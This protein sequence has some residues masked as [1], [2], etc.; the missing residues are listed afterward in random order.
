MNQLKI[1]LTTVGGVAFPSTI[2]AFREFK[3]GYRV[4][5]FGTDKNEN[6]VGKFFVNKFF[7]CED[8]LLNPKKFNN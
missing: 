3:K 2:N 4:V 7:K 8:S 6:A 5:I 1:L